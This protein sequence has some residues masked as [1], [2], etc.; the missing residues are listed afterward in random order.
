MLRP[1]ALYLLVNALIFVVIA[2]IWT[3]AGSSAEEVAHIVLVK[4]QIAAVAVGVFIVL[5]KFTALTTGFMLV[6]V[7]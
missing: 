2:V 1:F 7:F 4:T 5:V 6:A 3:L